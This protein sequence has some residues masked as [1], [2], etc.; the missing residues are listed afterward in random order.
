MSFKYIGGYSLLMLFT[1]FSL[2]MRQALSTTMQTMMT[3]SSNASPA[4]CNTLILTCP[5]T[6]IDLPGKLR[7]PLRTHIPGHHRMLVI[8]YSN[9]PK[10]PLRGELRG[11]HILRIRHHASVEQVHRAMGK[12]GIVLRVCHHD[13]SRA[14]LIQFG[15]EVHHLGAVLRIEVT[16]RLVR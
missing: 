4:K 8:Q 13:N 5:H 16:C 14:F 10:L 11:L 1:G 2:A 6:D 3:N 15:Q 12:G 9:I 7:E